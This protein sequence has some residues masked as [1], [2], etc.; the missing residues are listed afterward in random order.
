MIARLF[1]FALLA[2]LSLPSADSFSAARTSSE[3]EGV[4]CQ[5]SARTIHPEIYLTTEYK[6]GQCYAETIPHASR[7]LAIFK[8]SGTLLQAENVRLELTRWSRRCQIYCERQHY[9]CWRAGGRYC[10]ARYRDCLRGC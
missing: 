10:N 5:T 6:G 1:T 4:A 7:L 9:R 3:R 2:M 8:R